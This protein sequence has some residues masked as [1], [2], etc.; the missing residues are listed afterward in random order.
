[1]LPPIYSINTEITSALLN[2]FRL[3]IRQNSFTERGAR[4]RNELPR[5]E[6]WKCSGATGMWHTGL[7]FRA[8]CGGTR[9]MA[10]LADLE[11]LSQAEDSVRRER[12]QASSPGGQGRALRLG[13]T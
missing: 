11:G 10:G 13:V 7:R 1:M 12:G 2:W 3:G 9:L 5:E 4:H 8:G 6:V